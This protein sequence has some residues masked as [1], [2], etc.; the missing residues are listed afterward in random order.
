MKT[1][2]NK[3]ITYTVKDWNDTFTKVVDKPMLSSYFELI[4][5][6]CKA[7]IQGGYS[8]DDIKSID[9]VIQALKDK[10]ESA[11]FED[12]DFTFVQG[13]VTTY[14]WSVPEPQFIEF[15]DYIKGIK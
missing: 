15:V 8:Y 14:K 11:E 5:D 3:D 2:N 6:C 10:N 1:V 9:R 13:K 4:A 7:P 12:G